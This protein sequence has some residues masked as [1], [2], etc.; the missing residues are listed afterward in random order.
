MSARGPLHAFHHPDSSDDPALAAA[1]SSRSKR[2]TLV[3]GAVG[4]AVLMALMVGSMLEA[5]FTLLAEG[6]GRIGVDIWAP[7]AGLMVL[8]GAMI[9]VDR[10]IFLAS[11]PAFALGEEPYDE[12]Q[13]QLVARAREATIAIALVGVAGLTAVGASPAPAGFV[14]A[15]GLAAFALI[16][17]GQQL[18]LAWTLSQDEFD[19]SGES[20]DA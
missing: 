18:V 11:R 17:S 2:R 3:L 7:G 12:R 15:A 13:A 1:W 9:W 8:A 10:A 4:L 16:L 14:L 5:V 6:E 20:G 19:V